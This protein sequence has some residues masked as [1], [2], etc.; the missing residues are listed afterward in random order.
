MDS[1]DSHKPAANGTSSPPQG[2]PVAPADAKQPFALGRWWRD[3]RWHAGTLSYTTGGLFLL[4]FW[5]LGGDFG[6]Q[7]KERTVLPTLQLLVRQFKA[8]DFLTGL[9]LLSLPQAIAIVANPVFGYLSDRYR[10]RWGRR[11]PFLIILTPVAVVAMIGLAFAP[12]LGLSLHHALGDWSPGQNT[13]SIVVLAIFW[14]V[15]E[16]SSIIC[17]ALLVALVTDVVPKEIVG[18]FFALF[19]VVGLGAGMLFNY[20]LFG[21]A[22]EHYFPIFLSIAAVYAITFTLMCLKVKEDKN[23]P[24]PPPIPDARGLINT[25]LQAAHSYL[26]ECFANPY[27]RWVFLASAL[28][29]TAM[30]P[31]NLYTIYYAQSLD[32]DMATLGKYG[33]VLLFIGLVQAYPIGWLVDKFH[34][35]RVTIVATGLFVVVALTS[36]FT[37]RSASDFGIAYIACGIMAAFWVT[38]WWPLGTMLFPKEKFGAFNS[39]QLVANAIGQVLVGPICGWTLDLMGHDYRYIYLWVAGLAILALPAYLIVYRKFLT[40]GGLKAYV[41]PV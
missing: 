27:Y 14:S 5:L 8:S 26:R 13:L 35:L 38:A 6:I 15:F 32:M 20:Y 22:Q 2:P 11:I 19:R 24:P 10:S 39:V 12:A 31:L 7:I 25:F 33:T 41:P 3:K 29:F 17:M 9:L 28:G 40:F 34:S 4:F 21:K 23:L 16:F 30:A 36:F 18:R 1:S 37:V